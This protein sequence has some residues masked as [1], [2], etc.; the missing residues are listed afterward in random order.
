[1]HHKYDR[2]PH[3]TF[4][5]S[6]TMPKITTATLM[7]GLYPLQSTPTT[8]MMDP[9]RVRDQLIVELQK[10]SE[11]FAAPFLRHLARM[12]PKSL[13]PYSHIEFQLLQYNVTIYVVTYTHENHL[14]YRIKHLENPPSKSL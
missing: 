5:R 12:P 13:D 9:Y 2:S 1:M 8:F 6:N 7:A 10:R 11:P 14:L 3:Y 4:D